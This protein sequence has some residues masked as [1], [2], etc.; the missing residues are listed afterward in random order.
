MFTLTILALALTAQ[1]SS[2]RHVRSTEPTI[3]TL[4]ED[5]IAGSATFRSLIETLNESDVIVYIRLNRNR[6]ALGG[7]LAHTIVAQGHYRYLSISVETA[8]SRRRLVSLLAHELQHAVEVAHA[9][10][11]RDSES[12]E[13]L[14][15]GLAV[16]F[17]CG[18]TSCFETQAAK[19]VERTV[20]EEFAMPSS[21]TRRTRPA[22]R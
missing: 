15:S 7:Y 4:I 17:G 6:Q 2:A 21:V 9:P 22:N 3:V 1:D 14:F 12:L 19:D 20:N 18:G 13:R 10:G 16:K 5:G 11:A 8:G